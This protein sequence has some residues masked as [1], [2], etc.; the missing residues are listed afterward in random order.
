MVVTEFAD[1]QTI[2][3]DLVTGERETLL[4]I[5]GIIDNSAVGPDD[6]VYSAAFADGEIWAIDPSGDTRRVT[7]GGLMAVGGVAREEDGSVLVADWFS[8][9]RYTDGQLA[10]TFYDRF[11][12]PGEGMSGPNTVAVDGSDLI[13][14]GFFSN[15]LQV[16]D[17]TTGEVSRDVRDLK[18]PTNAIVHGDGIAVAEAGSADGSGPGDVVDLDTRKVLI[19]GL[20]LPTGL[21]S[22]GTTVY[23]ADWRT[24]DVWST[25]PAG[26]VLVAA[27]LNRPEG[28]ALTEDGRLLVAEE[29]IDQ[30][31]SIDLTTGDRFAAA[32]VPLGDHYAPGLLPYGMLTGITGD[33]AGGFWVSGDTDNLLYHYAAS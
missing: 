26:K 15:V 11:D 13:I 5:E 14:T 30:V 8:L 1:G 32:H 10:H 25:G 24:G 12:P 29:G 18:T 4:D 23:V 6:T 31:T 17:A 7:E 19:D 27:S 22:D 3:I 33:G 20:E 2:R 28:L 16:L 21:V 9:K